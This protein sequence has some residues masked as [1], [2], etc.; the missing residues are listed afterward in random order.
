MDDPIDRFLTYLQ[1]ECGFSRHT[2]EAYRRDLARFRDLSGGRLSVASVRDFAAAL[3]SLGLAPSSVAR[4]VASLRSL[5]RFLLAEG[6]LREDLRRHVS[7]PRIPASLPHPLNVRDVHALLEAPGLSLRDRA[8]LELLYASGI[9]A[10]ELTH[11]RVSDVNLDVGFVR[12]HGKGGKERVVPIGGGAVR[13][14]RE[15]VPAGEFLFPIRRETLWRVVRRAARRAGLKDVPHPHTLRHSFATHL[16]Q[17]GADL[18]YV[19]E[20]LGHSKISTTQI[21]THVD[22]ERLRQI[23]RRFH[24]RA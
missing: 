21:Y 7:A 20:M 22:H 13:R 10:S 5:L 14:L 23:H 12:C 24:P 17:N 18:R 8:M 9:R 19:Q 3:T 15:Y 16:V 6:E 2:V 1:V 4:H 11:L